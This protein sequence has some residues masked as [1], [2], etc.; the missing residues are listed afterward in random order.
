MNLVLN[1]LGSSLGYLSEQGEPRFSFGESHQGLFVPF[2]DNGIYFPVAQTLSAVDNGWTFFDAAAIRQFASSI[3]L[4]VAFAAFLLATQMPIQITTCLFVLQNILIDPFMTEA[5]LLLLFQS[6][7]DLFRT[8]ILSQPP[9]GVSTRAHIS[10][11]IL[12]T[13]FCLRSIARLWACC[14]R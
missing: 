4:S 3:V 2:S 9:S 11:V 6:A 14:G 5:N 8:P 12:G 7:R 10:A 13:P 1:S